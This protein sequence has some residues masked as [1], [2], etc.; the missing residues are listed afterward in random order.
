MAA[1]M[2]QEAPGAGVDLGDEVREA[3]KRVVDAIEASG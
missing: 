2:F 3:S 1:V